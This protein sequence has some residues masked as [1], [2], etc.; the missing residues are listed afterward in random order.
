MGIKDLFWIDGEEDEP[1]EPI[2]EI[3]NFDKPVRDQIQSVSHEYDIKVGEILKY[4]IKQIDLLK[5]IISDDI[6]LISVVM[7]NFHQKY[8]QIE[9]HE[10]LSMLKDSDLILTNIRSEIIGQHDRMIDKS[11]LDVN[12]SLDDTNDQLV[13]LELDVKNLQKIKVQLET[14]LNVGENDKKEFNKKVEN[15]II[16]MKSKNSMYIKL[17]TIGV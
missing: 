10:L 4:F 14:E 7:V 17:L 9:E 15:D 5:P 8:N 3:V 2:K 11:L 12:S 13:P 1:I 6:Q 16:N